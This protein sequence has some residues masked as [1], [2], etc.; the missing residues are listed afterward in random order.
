MDCMDNRTFNSPPPENAGSVKWWYRC[1]YCNKQLFP[2][3]ED[4][5]IEHLP[6]R[7]KACKHDLEI[8]VFPKK[9]NNL[10]AKSH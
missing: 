9:A 4:T 1:P 5:R 8:D 6:Y 10:R 2:I 7:C 3:R